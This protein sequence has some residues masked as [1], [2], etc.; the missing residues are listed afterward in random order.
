MR[1]YPIN[2]LP[3]CLYLGKQTETGVREVRLDCAPWLALWPDLSVSVWVTPPG[4]AD[5][6]PVVTHM[7]G[8]VLVWPVMDSDTAVAGNGYVEIM[9][10]TEGKKKLSATVSTYIAGTTTG[11]TA[12]PP[13]PAQPW[14]D[15]VLDAAHRAEDAAE[16]AESAGGEGGSGIDGEDGGYYTPQVKNGYLSWTA[17]KENMPAVLSARVRGDD[18]RDGIDGKS[19]YQYAQEGGYRG[20]EADFADKLATEWQRKLTGAEG[21]VV[22][23]D[24]NGNAIVQTLTADEVSDAVSYTFF[25]MELSRE[26]SRYQPKLSGSFRQ[27]V[28]FDEDG[29]VHVRRLSVTDVSGAA[30]ASEIEHLLHRDDIVDNLESENTEQPLSANQGRVLNAKI[31]Y[32]A[33]PTVTEEDNGKVLG[34]VDGKWTAVDAPE[35]GTGGGSD[36]DVSAAVEEYLAAHPYTI[37]GEEPDENR[38]F[39]VNT[40]NDVEISDLESKLI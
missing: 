5:A 18:G 1:I 39:V 21:Q 14:V 20:T 23:F 40:L 27:V 7:E 36:I 15:Q 26:L 38:N 30:D 33:P 6:Y 31:A 16:R 11:T 22:G 2:D 13:E 28:T 19:A 34:V 37:N 9:G 8:D 24:A 25:Q 35:G 32:S 3:S 10:V 12:E 29:N 17:S 4:G